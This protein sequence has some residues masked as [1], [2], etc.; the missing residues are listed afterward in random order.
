MGHSICAMVYVITIV[1]LLSGLKANLPRTL[2]NDEII[3]R[4][5][6]NFPVDISLSV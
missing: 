6:V 5:Y 3:Q 4:N 1:I 2:M